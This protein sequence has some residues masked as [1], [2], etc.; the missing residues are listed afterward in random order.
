MPSKKARNGD[1]EFNH[2]NYHEQSQIEFERHAFNSLIIPLL[3]IIPTLRT[4]SFH[5]S[6]AGIGTFKGMCTL[7]FV[8]CGQHSFPR[9]NPV[10]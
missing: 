9:R 4:F 6:V 1:R 10:T 8:D 7:M 3:I 2:Y 5:N